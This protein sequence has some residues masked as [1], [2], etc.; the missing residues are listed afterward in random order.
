MISEP[1]RLMYGPG[2]YIVDQGCY[3]GVKWKINKMAY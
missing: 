1:T 3:R 2:A